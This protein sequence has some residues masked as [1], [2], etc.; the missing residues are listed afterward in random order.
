MNEKYV[1]IET[2]GSIGENA[3]FGRNRI[4]GSKVYLEKEKA[5]GLVPQSVLLYL[6]GG[7]LHIL[8][9]GGGGDAEHCCYHCREEGDEQQG[10]EGESSYCFHALS[11]MFIVAFILM[12]LLPLLFIA[13][14]PFP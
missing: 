7:F 4:V 1:V 14:F 9:H 13:C 11:L 2:G 12:A 6:H 5:E 3:N 10:D 8:P